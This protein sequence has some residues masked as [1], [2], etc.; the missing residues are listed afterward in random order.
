MTSPFDAVNLPG[1]LPQME[2][3]VG[4]I[5][6]LRLVVKDDNVHFSMKLKPDDSELQT[7]DA[8]LGY[9]KNG[10]RHQMARNSAEFVAVAIGGEIKGGRLRTRDGSTDQ[11]S[12]S[13]AC[14]LAVKSPCRFMVQT[15]GE[16]TNLKKLE[17]L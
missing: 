5:D 11:E 1:D 7:F 13:R 3:V 4:T 17:M 8:Y 14:D 2:W 6:T 9:V 15:K 10:E 16:F 12:I